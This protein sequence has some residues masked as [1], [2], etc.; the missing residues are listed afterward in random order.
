MLPDIYL[1]AKVERAPCS[2][3]MPAD[4][5]DALAR[6]ARSSGLTIG[7]LVALALALYLADKKVDW[8]RTESEQVGREAG[9]PET[10]EQA[11]L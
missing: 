5:D 1:P 11:A 9:S 4:L 7:A 8:K 6:L 3:R 10:L 2:V